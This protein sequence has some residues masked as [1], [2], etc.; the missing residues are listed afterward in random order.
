MKVLVV[1][2]AGYLGG[3]VT[4]LLLETKHDIRVFDALLY[5][6]SYRKQIPFIYGDIRDRERLLPHLKWADSVVWLAALVGDG[7]CALNPE[8]SYQI[9]DRSVG[10]LSKNY[11]RRIIFTS[12]CSV[13]GEHDR[14]LDEESPTNPLSVYASTKLN[15]EKHLKDSDALIFRLGTLFG[16]SDSFSRIRMDLV[17]N[18]LTAKAF[19]EKKLNIFGGNQ[20]RP[21]LHVFDAASVIVGNLENKRRGIYNVTMQNIKMI[22]L[23]KKYKKHF[24]NLE[25]NLTPLKFQDPRNYRVSSQKA[26]KNLNFKPKLSIDKGIMEIRKILE[27]HRIKNIDSPR[28]TNQVFLHMFNTH[29]LK[30]EKK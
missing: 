8:V 18:T 13:Y 14:I 27:E 6:E 9:N 3:A 30:N 1:G 23:A 29:L 7:A 5:E 12:T 19:Y 28:H 17:V 2:G 11:D 20:Y 10:W 15:A 4:E 21:V 16:L 26:K 24:K 22:D 25:I